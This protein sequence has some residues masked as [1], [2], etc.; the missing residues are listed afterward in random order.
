MRFIILFFLPLCFSWGDELDDLLNKYTS[1]DIAEFISEAY[2][3]PVEKTFSTIPGSENFIN[4]FLLNKKEQDI[5]GIWGFDGVI[6]RPN[7]GDGPGTSV[8]L[9]PNRYFCIYKRSTKQNK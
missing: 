7:G 8:R 9:L 1:E 3:E 6:A 4:Q 2:I 5:I